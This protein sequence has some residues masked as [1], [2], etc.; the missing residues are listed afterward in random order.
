MFE[1]LFRIVPSSVFPALFG[2]AVWV[3]ASYFYL[4]PEVYQ[5]VTKAMVSEFRGQI[6]EFATFHDLTVSRNGAQAYARCVYDEVAKDEDFQM[7][8]AVWVA[9]IGHYGR[10]RLK[11]MKPILD[12]VI[13][14]DRCG[15]RPWA[16]TE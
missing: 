2:A 13:E 10:P 14:S 7:D 15:T 1:F 8:F 12:Q 6:L 5:R 4:A 3:G 9:T 16:I 11:D